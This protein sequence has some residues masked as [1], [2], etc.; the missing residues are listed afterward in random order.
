MKSLSVKINSIIIAVVLL[1]TL[2]LGVLNYVNEKERL[3]ATIKSEAKGVVLRLTSSLSYPIWNLNSVEV[4]VITT[5]EMSNKNIQCIEIFDQYRKK[6]ISVIG[7][8]NDWN[9]IQLSKGCS[10]SPSEKFT[11]VILY[12]GN[13]IGTVSVHLSDAIIVSKIQSQTMEYIILVLGIT[14]L[15]VVALIVLIRIIVLTPLIKLKKAFGGPSDVV[16]D[17][18]NIFR[19]DE[20]GMLT[21]SFLEMQHRIASLF[22]ERDDKIK[23]LELMRS[24]LLQ[25]REDLRV[26]LE[27]LG[28]GVIATN[29]QGSI[30]RINSIAVS[31]TGWTKEEAIDKELSEV[32]VLVDPSTRKAVTVNVSDLLPAVAESKKRFQALLLNK[33]DKECLIAISYVGIKSTDET[34]VGMVMVYS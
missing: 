22:T 15:V 9:P 8:D 23:E 27:S 20:I 10:G 1:V 25:E 4:E 33:Y 14:C 12:K 11:E 2:L 6:N 26:T 16:E 30:T 24:D 3:H 34:T 19:N 17:G 13:I 5:S 28:E 7:R 29:M 18:L 31:L 21:R 32:L